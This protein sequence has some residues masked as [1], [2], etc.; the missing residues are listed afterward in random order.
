[1]VVDGGAATCEAA[2]NDIGRNS[3]RRKYCFE[4]RTSP[5]TSNSSA[6]SM[7]RCP[8]GETSGKNFAGERLVH[9]RDSRRLGRVA[10]GERA[11]GDHGHFQCGEIAFAD[12]VADDFADDLPR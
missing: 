2:V 9:D 12:L 8:S 1:M 3:S 11:A 10:I 6:P 5:T 7:N 4:S